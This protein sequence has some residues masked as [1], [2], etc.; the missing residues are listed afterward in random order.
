ML[1]TAATLTLPSS[2]HTYKQN[3]LTLDFSTEIQIIAHLLNLFPL[4]SV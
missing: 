4:G 3:A 2:V 1:S